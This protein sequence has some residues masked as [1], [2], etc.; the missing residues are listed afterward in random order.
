MCTR[1]IPPRDRLDYWRDAIGRT[2][3][4]LTSV[5]LDISTPTDDPY[6]GAIHVGPVGPLGIATAHGDP[7][8]VHNPCR[9]PRGRAPTTST[10]AS[11]T[12]AAW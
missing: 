10:S 3:Q 9:R 7:L 6:E 1:R 11:R 8:R 12:A 2:Y 5:R 4:E